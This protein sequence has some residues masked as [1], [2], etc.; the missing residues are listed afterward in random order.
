MYFFPSDLES[1]PS[2]NKLIIIYNEDIVVFLNRIKYE[3]IKMATGKRLV[4]SF[5]NTVSTVQIETF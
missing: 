4:C 5:R 1:S 2:V 3:T